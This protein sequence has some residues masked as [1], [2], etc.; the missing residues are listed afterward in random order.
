MEYEHVA[1][2]SNAVPDDQAVAVMDREARADDSLIAD[3]NAIEDYR[4]SLQELSQW[5]KADPG[6]EV[7][8]TVERN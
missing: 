2:N 8:E 1:T 3:I 4:R 6:D 5:P 7:T